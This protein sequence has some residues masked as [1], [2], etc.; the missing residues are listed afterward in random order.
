MIGCGIAGIKPESAG[1]LGDA[2]VATAGFLGQFLHLR[3]GP[4]RPHLCVVC[5]AVRWDGDSARRSSQI[6][7]DGREDGTA[8]GRRGYSDVHPGRVDNR[9]PPRGAPYEKRSSSS[10]L[11]CEDLREES[12]L[13]HLCSSVCICGSSTSSAGLS[14]A[15]GVHA[16]F[17]SRR[18]RWD[19]QMLRRG[20][21]GPRRARAIRRR[22]SR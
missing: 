10:A 3:L 19:R 22:W 13:S 18:S 20:G 9:I 8:A 14:R 2:A 12:P 15:G 11:I 1:R 4:D 21:G 16:V 5:R 17:A 7:A 6:D